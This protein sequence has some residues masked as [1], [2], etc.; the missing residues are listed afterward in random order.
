MPVWD[1]IN[2]ENAVRFAG[3]LYSKSMLLPIHYLTFIL[4]P[5]DMEAVKSKQ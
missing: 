2:P 3:E 4:P 5:P 1:H